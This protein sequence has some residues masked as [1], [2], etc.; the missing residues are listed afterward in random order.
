MQALL[1]RL[2]MDRGADTRRKGLGCVPRRSLGIWRK[3]AFGLLVHPTERSRRD[4]I[5][6]LTEYCTCTTKA[7]MAIAESADKRPPPPRQTW[8]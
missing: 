7:A 2:C 1:E 8:Q 6:E 4:N 3:I 5:F